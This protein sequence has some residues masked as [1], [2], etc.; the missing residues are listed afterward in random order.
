MFWEV[1]PRVRSPASGSE[2]HRPSA[3]VLQLLGS[4]APHVLWVRIWGEGL[5]GQRLRLNRA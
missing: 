2:L 5:W 4:P 1:G 3:E